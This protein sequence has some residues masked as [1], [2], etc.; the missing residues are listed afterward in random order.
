MLH[1]P[2]ISRSLPLDPSSISLSLVLPVSP[3]ICSAPVDTLL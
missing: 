3:K 2:A 1:G